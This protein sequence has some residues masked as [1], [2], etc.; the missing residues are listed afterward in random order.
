M[1]TQRTAPRSIR[2]GLLA[3]HRDTL[4]PLAAAYER[5]W[6]E[7]YGV[8]GDAIEDLRAR[9]RRTGLPVGLVALEQDVAIGALAIAETSVPTH[10]H[11]S[12]WLVG[13]WVEASRRNR[14]I[15]AQLVLSAC[16]H[17]RRQGIARLY[18]AAAAASGLFAREGWSV[19]DA[20]TTE[21]GVTTTIFSKA[22]QAS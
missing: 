8:H 18:V 6:P 1:K 19:I 7:W 17:A 13:F 3:D 9:S 11:L 21:L 5:Q 4:A 16:D 14:G 15:G 22:L 20:G 2:I 12:P 10:P